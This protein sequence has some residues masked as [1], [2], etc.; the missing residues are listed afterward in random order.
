MAVYLNDQFLNNEQAQL[1]VSDL[2]MQRGYAIFDFFRTVN[3]VPLFIDDHLD[4]FYASA[5][6]MHL[7][8]NKSREELKLIVQELLHRSSLAEAGIRLLLTG[9]YAADSY[10]IASPNLVITCNP[11]KT[12]TPDDFEKGLLVLTYE[13]QRELPHIKSINYI[14]AVWLQP[15]LKEK[16]ADDVLY[17]NKESITE[18][19]RCNVFIVTKENKLV[20]PARNMLRGITRKNVLALAATSIQVEERDISIAEL[21]SASEV[22]LTSTSK[23]ILPVLTIDNTII[24]NG[25]PGPVTTALYRQFIA[26]ERNVI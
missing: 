14:M 26:L 19:P 10:S 23:K 11:V 12:A 16:K 13:H 1:Q 18:F 4:R 24:G 6:A 8:M 20:T 5:A 15:L 3:G 7:P 2:S 9:G 21:F 25:R 17:H 22:F